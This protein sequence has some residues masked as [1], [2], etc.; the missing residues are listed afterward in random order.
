MGSMGTIVMVHIIQYVCLTNS[1]VPL[2]TYYHS[3]E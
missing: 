1:Q 2:H 3:F